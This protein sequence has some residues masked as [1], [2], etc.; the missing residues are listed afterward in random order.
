MIYL[1][2]L[3]QFKGHRILT[4]ELRELFPHP[5]HF[6]HIL[7]QGCHLAFRYLMTDI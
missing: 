4:E 2:A 6:L 1:E 7:F 5:L 3:F